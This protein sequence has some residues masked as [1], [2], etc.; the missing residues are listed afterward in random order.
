MARTTFAVLAMA[1]LIGGSL[2]VLRTFIGPGIWAAML[3]VA[4]WPLMLRLQGWLGGRRWAAVLA[5]TLALL[6]LFVVPLLLA[7]GTIAVN[8]EVLA[9]WIRGIAAWRVP[10]EAPGWL[11]SLPLVGAQI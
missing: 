3:V 7:I 5:M 10:E 6:L 2:W 9:G 8:V 4:S 1:L 11:R